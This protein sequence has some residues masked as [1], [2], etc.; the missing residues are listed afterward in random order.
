MKKDKV[1]FWIVTGMSGAG[2]SQVINCFEDFGFFCVDNLPIALLPK[3][4]ELCAQSGRPLRRVALGIDIREGG[5]LRD[6]MAAIS[7]L[8]QQGVACRILFLDADDRT[9]IRRFSETRRRH[10][11]GNSVRKGISE[12]R[13]RLLKIKE[14]ADKIIDTSNMTLADLKMTLSGILERRRSNE[15]QISI[16]SFGY[17]YGLPVD[18]DIIWDVRFMPNPN[19]QKHLRPKTGRDAAVRRYVM[20]SRQAQQLGRKFF[21]LIT[22]SLPYYIGEGKS[23]LTIAIGCTGG[24]HRSVV[25][26]D[27]LREDLLDHGFKVHVL[28][29]DID[30]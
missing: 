25:I 11:L 15:M 4:A 13:R 9:L 8:K 2:K 21:S 3:M 18:V 29:R 16:V 30:R 23:Y 19:Y 26:A 24:R 7:A 27:A 14:I 10:P 1:L 17:K 20:S 6:F 28:H 5:F 22:E 12:E